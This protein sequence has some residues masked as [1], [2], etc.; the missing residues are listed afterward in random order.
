MKKA[1]R[2]KPKGGHFGIMQN[3]EMKGVALPMS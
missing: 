3:V 1:A 2:K